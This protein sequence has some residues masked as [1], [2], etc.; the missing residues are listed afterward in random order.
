MCKRAGGS[1]GTARHFDGDN[2]LAGGNQPTNFPSGSAPHSTE[3]WIRPLRPNTTIV[4][5]GIEK[6]Q[7]KVVVQFRSP[8]H[9]QVDAYFS[10]ANVNGKTQ[11]PT[12]EWTHVLHT[13]EKGMPRRYVNVQTDLS[14]IPI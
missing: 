2:G 1:I 10:D 8:P 14:L 3:A 13:F 4:G 9:V 6:A 7:S 12:G 11:V 5:W